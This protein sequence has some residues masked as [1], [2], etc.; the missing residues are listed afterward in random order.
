ME[1]FQKLTQYTVNCASK[2]LVT[3]YA[4]NISVLQNKVTSI[5]EKCDRRTLI[6]LFFNTM[7]LREKGPSVN[8]N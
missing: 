7:N 1:E 4:K 6:L 2:V 5:D 8:A 3:V